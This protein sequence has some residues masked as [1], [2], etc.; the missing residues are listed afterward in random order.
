[1][2]EGC[3]GDGETWILSGRLRKGGGGGK[4]VTSRGDVGDSVSCILELRAG[5][6]GVLFIGGGGRG[7]TLV[8]REWPIGLPEDFTGSSND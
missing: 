8:V 3:M 6:P 1:V 2:F 5:R 4:V 7:D